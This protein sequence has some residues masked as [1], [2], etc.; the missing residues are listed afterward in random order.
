MSQSTSTKFYFELN[1]LGEQTDFQG[2]EHVATTVALRDLIK[3]G[4]NPFKYRIPSLPKG[5]KITLK[6][7]VCKP[8]SRVLDWMNPSADSDKEKDRATLCLKDDNGNILVEWVLFGA[9]PEGGQAAKDF[10]KAGLTAIEK[11]DV[12]FGF[13]TLKLK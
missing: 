10:S 1:I 8:D 11:L 3:P 6:K 5:R 4:D 13:Y 2:V 7:G 12:S 9:R